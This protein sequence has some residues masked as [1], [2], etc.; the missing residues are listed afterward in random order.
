[1][2]D[3][4]RLVTAEKARITPKQATPFFVDKLTQLCTHLDRKLT[5]VTDSIDRFLLARDQAYFKMAFF[6]GDRPGDLGQI[7]VPKIPRFPNDDGMLFNHVWGKTL[8]D[9]D[10]NVFGIRRNEQK[11]ICPIQAIERYMDIARQMGIDLTRGYLFRPTTPNKGI[12]DSALTSSAAEARLKLYL[13]EM[14]ADEGETLH[15]FRAGC[16]ITLALSGA[17]LAKIM[18]HVGWSRR[19]TAVYYMQLAKFLNSQAASAKL[20]SHT[21]QQPLQSWQDINELKRFVC[22]FPT[23]HA[24]KRKKMP[25]REI[26]DSYEWGIRNGKERGSLWKMVDIVLG[27]LRK[28]RKIAALYLCPYLNPSEHE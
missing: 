22:A 19:H 4:L 10:A 8:R 24:K 18:E 1:M 17:D 27:L 20:A 13:K 26:W 23:S 2:K 15:D 7:K 25:F 11:V 3:Y 6:S 12:Q 28:V 5:T 14:H 16:A 9:G 21:I